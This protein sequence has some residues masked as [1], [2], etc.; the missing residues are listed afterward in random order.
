MENPR[1]IILGQYTSRDVVRGIS[2]DY[3]FTVIVK[4]PEDRGRSEC[5]LEGRKG[6]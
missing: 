5:L 1:I 4:M 3:N 6:L 2:F